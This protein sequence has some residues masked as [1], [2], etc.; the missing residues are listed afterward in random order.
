MATMSMTGFGRG[1]CEVAGRRFVVE[2]RAVNHR[3]L[4][5]KTRLPWSDP[6]IEQQVGQAVR[7]RL[8]RGAVTLS[9]REEGAGHGA[10]QVHVDLGL[11]R[12]VAQA[13]GELAAA[14]GLDERPSLA[15][16]AAQ[17]GVLIAGAEGAAGEELWAQLQPGVDAALDELVAARAREGEALRDDLL[18]RTRLLRATVTE[19]ARLAA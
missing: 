13:L 9:V 3:F 2:I 6:L 4:E 5:L 18:A 17:P 15:V 8:A 7:K 11:G 10:A 1:R 19:V 16:I 12:A 14:C